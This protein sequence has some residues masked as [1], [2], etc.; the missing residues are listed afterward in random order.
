MR[1]LYVEDNEVNQAL[2]ERVMRA[3]QC[4]VI[5]REEGEGAL[6]ILADDADIDLVLMD[7]ELAGLISGLDVVRALRARNDHR[8]VV[9]VTAYAMM[10]DR[11][12]ILEAGCDQYLPKPL[13]ISDLLN[14][15]DDYE[16]QFAAAP[17][18]AETPATATPAAA[19]SP[20][21]ESPVA[22]S[23]PA[24]TPAPPPTPA[25]DT[26]PAATPAVPTAET[27]APTTPAVPAPAE[28]PATKTPAPTATPTAAT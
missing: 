26:T 17:A 21:A 11:E 13:V 4:D 10:G 22:A 25:A 6:E 5:F 24:S 28:T 1:V 7:I 12:R 15:L 2:V 19:P 14:L 8:P 27:A 9:A 3:R 23:T 20:T 18:P 16:Q